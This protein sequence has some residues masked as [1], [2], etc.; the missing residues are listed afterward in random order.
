MPLL[1]L[2]P[3]EKG[4]GRMRMAEPSG[5]HRTQQIVSSFCI[6]P[7]SFGEGSPAR[8]LQY[9]RRLYGLSEALEPGLDP[10][11]SFGLARVKPAD[12]G[13]SRRLTA[14]PP[15]LRQALALECPAVDGGPG[16]RLECV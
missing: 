3:V 13:C 14:W 16:L 6:R 15:R 10:A 12:F 9:L 8:R 5:S 7:F 2:N 4:E 11:L 1:H